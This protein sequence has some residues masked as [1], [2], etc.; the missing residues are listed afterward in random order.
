M[1]KINPRILG[2]LKDKEKENHKV[3]DQILPEWSKN[4]RLL[5]L[6]GQLYGRQH[7]HLAHGVLGAIPG[8]TTKRN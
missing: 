1:K 3:Q 5:G 8:T 7:A 6:W 4:W 2:I